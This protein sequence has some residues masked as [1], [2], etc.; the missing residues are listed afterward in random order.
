M[1]NFDS[2]AAV[3]KSSVE[4]LSRIMNLDEARPGDWSLRDLPAMLRH[5]L[6]APL[7]FELSRL[8]AS[9]SPQ[10]M[11][12]GTLSGTFRDLFEHPK[13]PLAVLKATRDLF[14]GQA[15]TSAKRRPEQEVAYLMYLLAILIAQVRLGTSITKL[16]DADLL[17]GIR[18]SLKQQW[19]DERTRA[20]LAKADETL[21]AAGPD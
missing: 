20:L 6:S 5:Q 8:P 4:Q 7:E 21:R 12:D 18:W 9:K 17:K 14:K 3:F 1:A 11:R 10:T 15:G 16:C 19:V 13:P 2:S